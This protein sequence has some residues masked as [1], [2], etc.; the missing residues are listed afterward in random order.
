M[1]FVKKM[2]EEEYPLNEIIVGDS[3]RAL[4]TI[5]DESIE[6][7]VTSPP[8]DTMR[9]YKGFKFDFRPIARFLFRS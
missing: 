4:K 3:L 2:I 9:K 5:P 6:L 1:H 8:Y 7:V